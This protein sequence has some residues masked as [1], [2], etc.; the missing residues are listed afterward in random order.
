DASCVDRFTRTNAT[1]LVDSDVRR[2]VSEWMGQTPQRVER[3]PDDPQI[4]KFSGGSTGT[5]KPVVQSLRCIN[6]QA[7]G[8]RDFFEFGSDDVN[9]IAAPLTHGASCFVL[10]MLE[11][12]ARHVL[13]ADPKPNAIREA[14]A[15]H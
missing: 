3:T 12:G 10:P 4:I 13:L 2:L 11:A 7:D 5:P 6:A 1:L 14:I 15:K 8:L 9:L